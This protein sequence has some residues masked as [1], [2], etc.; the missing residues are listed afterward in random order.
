MTIAFQQKIDIAKQLN[1]ILYLKN[2]N[3]FNFLNSIIINPINT[4][5]YDKLKY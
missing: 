4:K 3:Y 2:L 5:I 1:Q